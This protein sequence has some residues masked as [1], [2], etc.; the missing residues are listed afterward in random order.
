MSNELKREITAEADAAALRSG[1]LLVAPEARAQCK[2]CGADAHL[3]GVVDFNRSCQPSNY[4]G[5]LVGVPVYYHRCKACHFVF[6]RAFDRFDPASWRRFIYND[7]YFAS[8][9]PAYEIARPQMNFQVVGAACRIIGRKKIVGIDYGG[10]NGV[11]A[12]LLSAQGIRYFTHDPYAES[13]VCSEDVGRFSFLSSFEVLEHTTDPVA[14]IKDMLRFVGTEFVAVISTQCSENLVD[15]EKRLSWTYIA[16]RHGHVSIY[17]KKALALLAKKFSM[18]Y[19]SVSRGTHLFGRKAP[20]VLLKY[21]IGM[22]KL[23]Q[24]MW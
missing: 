6:T 21:A 15:E 8:L 7:A 11:L 12:R 9:D 24:R 2:I 16:P 18:D 5:G 13:N 14:T 19:L 4:P 3:F 17:S 10:G 1:K 20:L 22:V 23:G